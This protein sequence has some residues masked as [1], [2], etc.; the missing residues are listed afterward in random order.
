MNPQ[1]TDAPH[2]YL[3]GYRGCGKSTIAKE[4]TRLLVLPLVDLDAFIEAEAGTTIAK[5]FQDETETGF[6][7]REAK[8]L[9]QVAT[10]TQRIISLGGGAI[11]SDPNRDIIART[12]WCVWLD[13]SPSVIAERLSADATTGDRRPSLTGTSVIEEIESVMQQREPL[14]RDASDLRIETDHRSVDEI[15]AQIVEAWNQR[16]PDTRSL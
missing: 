9:A 1:S 11:L 7:D 5:I 15:S 3:T 14:Y 6:R 4:L 16:Q 13:A 10:E 8:C 12:G 2:L